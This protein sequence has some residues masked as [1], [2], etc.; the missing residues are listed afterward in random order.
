[1]HAVAGAVDV[2][3]GDPL[4]RL[5]EVE[6]LAGEPRAH[7]AGEAPVAPEP[8]DVERVHLE[9]LA[10]RVPLSHSRATTVTCAP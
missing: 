6:R 4:V 8:T 7:R 2:A 1:M 5:H 10:A 3:A 9:H